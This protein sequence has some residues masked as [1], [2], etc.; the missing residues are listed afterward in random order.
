MMSISTIARSASALEHVDRLAA[1]AGGQH[2]HAA[3][4]EHA[5]QR[6]DVAHVVVDDQHR[7]ADQVLVRAVQP[8]EHLLLLGRQ[9]GDDAV[10]E[11]RGLVE[12]PLGRL[13]ALDHD[14][15]RERVQLRRPPR[16]TAPC[17]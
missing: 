9:V 7:L 3:P 4:L 17:R 14:A 5:G 12:Q 1:G 15:A 13:D 11:E 6:E 16:P 2:L 8:L 10:Q